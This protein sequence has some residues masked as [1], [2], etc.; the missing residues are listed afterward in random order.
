MKRV[1]TSGNMPSHIAAFAVQL[2]GRLSG[3]KETE[4]WEASSIEEFEKN[5]SEI[6]YEIVPS[7]DASTNRCYLVG[8]AVED[9][10]VVVVRDAYSQLKMYF[11]EISEPEFRAW[12]KKIKSHREDQQLDMMMRREQSKANRKPLITGGTNA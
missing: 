9:P 6:G 3:Q 11:I 2:Q 1:Y 12:V 4:F 8:F 10:V 7:M 5:A